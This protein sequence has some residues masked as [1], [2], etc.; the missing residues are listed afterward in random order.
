MEQRH[1]SLMFRI[2]CNVE[3][4]VA[5][6]TSS[7]MKHKQQSKAETEIS[8]CSSWTADNAVLCHQRVAVEVTATAA[9]IKPVCATKRTCDLV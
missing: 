7:V 4:H 6:M 9:V 2:T 1:S 5:C 8:K 3:Q